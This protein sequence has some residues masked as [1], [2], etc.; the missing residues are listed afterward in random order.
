[1]AAQKPYPKAPLYP[2]L[3][4][5]AL[6]HEQRMAALWDEKTATRSVGLAG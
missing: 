2:T 4:R 1:M 5:P 6:G 3:K